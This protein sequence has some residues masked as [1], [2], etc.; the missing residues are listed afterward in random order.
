MKY[1]FALILNLTATQ[2]YSY[3]Y[4]DYNLSHM[5]R[6]QRFAWYE[7]VDNRLEGES[8]Q[9]LF[10]T[11]CEASTNKLSRFC[12]DLYFRDCRDRDFE[13][14][15][16]QKVIG[17]ACNLDPEWSKDCETH[18]YEKCQKQEFKGQIKIV[19][20]ISQR[21]QIRVCPNIRTHLVSKL[22]EKQVEDVEKSG[23]EGLNLD[24]KNSSDEVTAGYCKLGGSDASDPFAKACAARKAHEAAQ[25]GTQSNPN[26]G[27]PPAC[28][29]L[30]ETL[31]SVPSVQTLLALR[32]RLKQEKLPD[33]CANLIYLKALETMATPTADGW[34]EAL[35]FD[36]YLRDSSG[37]NGRV[38]RDSVTQFLAKF[39][40]DSHTSVYF[41]LSGFDGLQVPTKI[42]ILKRLQL[43]KTKSG[44]ISILLYRLLHGSDPILK[45]EAMASFAS[46]WRFE[47]DA[48]YVVDVGKELKDILL[49]CV[50]TVS[51]TD[52]KSMQNKPDLAALSQGALEDQFC[53]L[54]VGLD[55]TDEID[56][57][58][59][60]IYIPAVQGRFGVESQL[61][62]LSYIAFMTPKDKKAE[63]LTLLDSILVNSKNY[64][65][66]LAILTVFAGLNESD[67]LI[68]A[69]DRDMWSFIDGN[70][71]DHD[72]VTGLLDILVKLKSIRPRAQHVNYVFSRGN[73][74]DYLIECQASTKN[75]QAEK[76]FC[77]DTGISFIQKIGGSISRYDVIFEERFYP[78]LLER[79]VSNSFEERSKII[80]VVR[81]RM[82]YNKGGQAA[83]PAMLKGFAELAL[84]RIK[85]IFESRLKTDPFL[86]QPLIGLARQ[87]VETGA[88]LTEF[89]KLPAQRSYVSDVLK[90]S[91]AQVS[92]KTLLEI[93]HDIVAKDTIRFVLDGKDYVKSFFKLKGQ[94]VFDSWTGPMPWVLQTFIQEGFINCM[95]D[96]A[97]TS[98]DR[99]LRSAE[100]GSLTDQVKWKSSRR[101][102]QELILTRDEF[103]AYDLQS[104]M[105][106]LYLQ[107]N[108][109]TDLSDQFSRWSLSWGLFG[110]ESVGYSFVQP[111]PANP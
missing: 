61:S 24:G 88:A 23:L 29:F 10:K 56:A 8:C 83:N 100:E 18:F 11:V 44:I 90:R 4:A 42:A 36:L 64:K 93:K 105:L 55:L 69:V 82:G 84:A 17:T 49:P 59:N 41:L 40:A 46:R 37:R 75:S 1:I 45:A 15:S 53:K 103:I 74:F 51:A 85:I 98:P 101:E 9:A 62:S 86:L 79:I 7:C 54:G 68:A 6:D 16:C 78:R 47:F 80:E 13:G 107:Q 87:D 97:G 48:N 99:C 66:R 72:Y 73:F 111:L 52:I 106:S 104:V 2:A 35:V 77:F 70:F 34:E 89:L 20:P 33:S 22:F 110:N 108:D 28:G 58:Y 31:N 67:R 3:I 60:D 95:P 71:T 19:N 91:W 39:G 76:D 27:T 50:K 57:I 43:M 102:V 92:F 38:L 109:L 14:D 63:L 94:L 32:L 5:S 81:G 25:I 26:S 30:T 12:I 21:E 65:V 96:A